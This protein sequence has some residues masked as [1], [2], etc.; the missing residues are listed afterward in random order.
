M[1]AARIGDYADISFCALPRAARGRRGAFTAKRRNLP[2]TILEDAEAVRPKRLRQ[3]INL[4]RGQR[5]LRLLRATQKSRAGAA[6]RSSR[7]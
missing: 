3:E 7:T 5:M 4:E 1:L 2:T 6:M